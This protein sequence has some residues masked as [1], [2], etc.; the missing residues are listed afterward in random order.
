VLP[1]TVMRSSL[2]ACAVIALPLA[3]TAQ[4]TTQLTGV[5]GDLHYVEE[6]GDVVGTE[7]IVSRTKAGYRVIFQEA[8]GVPGPVDTVPAAIKGDSL[9][10][11]LP[12]DTTRRLGP[13]DSVYIRVQRRVFRGRI[14]PK[15]L[16]GH[17]TGFYEDLDLPRQARSARVR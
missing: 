5:F 6:A 11:E 7:I 16:H 15:K 9:F 12:P 1:L 13:R 10:F 17:L 4:S 14:L 3:G 8:E 2:L